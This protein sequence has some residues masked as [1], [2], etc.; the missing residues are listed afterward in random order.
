MNELN[1]ALGDI[2]SIRRQVA[3]T[4]EFHGYGPLTLLLTACFAAVAGWAQAQW[5]PEPVIHPLRYV[6]VWAIA[7]LLSM[8]VICVST[9]TR[10]RRVHS[11]IANEMI[12]MAAEQFAPAFIA[13]ALLT[14]VVLVAA[15]HTPS[16][17][18]MLSGLWQIIYSL[19]IFASCRFL[20]RAM[21][22]AGVWYLCTGLL[23][24][25]ITDARALSPWHMTFAFTVGQTLI[26]LT[27]QL[28]AGEAADEA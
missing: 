28:F 18:W 19:G 9:L 10:T 15:H 7:A 17:V 24:I 11:G 27:L 13:G 1:R 20:P 23:C 16:A 21:G 4:T 2:R 3:L 26:A 14:A 8:A 25:S 12:R 5:V 22:A 6:T